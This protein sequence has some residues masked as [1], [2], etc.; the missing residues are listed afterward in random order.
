MIVCYVATYLHLNI[1]NAYPPFLCHIFHCLD[2]RPVVIPAKLGIFDKSPI[3]NKLQE[4]FLRREII[5][6]AILLASAWETS[7]VCSE[8]QSYELERLVT[9][10]AGIWGVTDVRR[11]SRRWTDGPQRGVSESSTCRCQR[12]LTLQLG[13][14]SLWLLGMGVSGGRTKRCIIANSPFGGIAEEEDVLI[15]PRGGKLK[16]F[17]IDQ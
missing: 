15:I 11:R 13:G 6:A 7:R 16:Y 4:R 17:G 3:L 10:E 5:F 14:G 12:A 8:A 9:F 2:A 1:Q